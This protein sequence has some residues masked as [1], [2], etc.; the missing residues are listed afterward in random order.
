MQGNQAILGY[1]EQGQLY[2]LKHGSTCYKVEWELGEQETPLNRI[3]ELAILR[4]HKSSDMQ[5]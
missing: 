3:F 1:S 2:V 5:I 4:D